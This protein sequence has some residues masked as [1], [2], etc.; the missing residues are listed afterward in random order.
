M[1]AVEQQEEGEI[2][3]DLL[4]DVPR[5]QAGEHAHQAGQQDQAQADPVEAEVVLDVEVG[6]PGP[7]DDQVVRRRAASSD[8]ARVARPARP[9][10]SVFCGPVGAAGPRRAIP[11]STYAA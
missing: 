2:P 4:L 3:L 5:R 9:G 11:G 7:A 8:D 1:L 6:D 10:S